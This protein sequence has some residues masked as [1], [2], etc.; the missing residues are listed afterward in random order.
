MQTQEGMK[1]K[2]VQVSINFENTQKIKHG[3]PLHNMVFTIIYM[4]ENILH[5]KHLNQK[6]VQGSHV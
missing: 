6:N 1:G 5:G 4:E 3:Q 2:P